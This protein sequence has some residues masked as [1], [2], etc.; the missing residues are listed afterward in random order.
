M[1]VPLADETMYAT[2]ADGSELTV[3]LRIGQSYARPAGIE[4]SIAN[5]GTT[6]ISFVETEK[7]A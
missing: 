1:V 2:N 5:R 6:T 3:T 4:H 7:L